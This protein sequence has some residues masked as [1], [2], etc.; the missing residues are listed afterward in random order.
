MRK[1][2]L[3]LMAV[4]ACAWNVSAQTRTIH[5]TVLDAANN[6]PLIGATIM[7]VGGGQGAAADIDGNFT[8]TVPA[9][10]KKATISYVGYKS[11]T[12]DIKNVKLDKD[13]F[14]EVLTSKSGNNYN[15]KEIAD[16]R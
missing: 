9:N 13:R 14:F 5:G 4:I 12:V 2:F 3:F 16:P 1:L 8:L 10:V 6:E 7:P 15:Y 11:Q